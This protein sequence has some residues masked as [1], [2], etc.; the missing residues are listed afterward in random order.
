MLIGGVSGC[1]EVFFRHEK[2]QLAFDGLIILYECFVV[3]S[4]G[5][6]LESFMV[7]VEEIRYFMENLL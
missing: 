4:C 1:S 7:V 5:R 6:I 2:H 3:V